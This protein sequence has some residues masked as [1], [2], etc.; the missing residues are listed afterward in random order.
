MEQA[1][2]TWILQPEGHYKLLRD[3]RKSLVDSSYILPDG[4]NL[5][6]CAWRLDNEGT[7]FYTEGKV[8]AVIAWPTLAKMQEMDK[9]S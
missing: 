6:K 7:K 9:T 4:T 3:P 2:D 5:S 1:L 8:V